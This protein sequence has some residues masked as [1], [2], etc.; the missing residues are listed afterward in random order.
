MGSRTV[1]NRCRLRQATTAPPSPDSAMKP[2]A[3]RKAG[4]VG[5]AAWLPA[6][7]YAAVFGNDAER[8]W[9]AG[10]PSSVIRETAAQ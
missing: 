3:T 9:R 8:P 10:R 4:E 2:K 6:T 1:R 5:E 7:T